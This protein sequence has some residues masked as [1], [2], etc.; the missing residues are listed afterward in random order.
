MNSPRCFAL[1][2]ALAL[3]GPAAAAPDGFIWLDV[4]VKFVVDPATGQ[5][6]AGT[7]DANLRQVFDLMNRWLSNTW[8]GYR[9]RLVDLDSNQHFPRIGGLNDVTGPSKWYTADLKNDSPSTVNY[10]FEA[11]AKA[12]PVTYAWNS[13]AANIYI[14]NGTW[15]RANFPSSGHEL[16]ISS[17]DLI[18]NDA[19]P[20]NYRTHNYKIAGNLLHEMGHFFE[21]YHTFPDDGIADTAPDNNIGSRDETAIRNSL[22]QSNWALNYAALTPAQKAQ[23]DNTANNAMS[24]YQLFYDDPAQNKTLT[25]AERFGP[26][27]FLFTE[28][29]MDKWCDNAN[30]QRAQVA[31]GKVVF[32]DRAV[33]TS[34]AGTSAAPVKTL[35]T[36]VTSASAS[37]R[38]ILLL[39][40]GTYTAAV[41]SKPLTIRATRNGAVQIQKP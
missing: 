11:A 25:D 27:R 9:L 5:A 20:E 33:V 8:R 17:F 36:A 6:P 18:S 35:A 19:A 28:L 14:N 7:D 37:G 41:L 21:L 13:T 10:A 26:S 22:A 4:S 40:P 38:D 15:S 16:V 1:L 12:A 29:Q 31:S 39:R 32:V 30:L 23:V 24:Y 3:V 2:L 34:G